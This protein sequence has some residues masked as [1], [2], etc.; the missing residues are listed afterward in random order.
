MLFSKA[1][2][3]A[4]RAALYISSRSENIVPIREISDELEISFHF[5]TKILQQLTRHHILTSLKGPKGGVGLNKPAE[6]ISLKSIVL[7]IDGQDFF[8]GCLLRLDK[9]SDAHPCPIH[10]E[11]K[12]VR[13]QLLN[14][15]ESTTLDQFQSKVKSKKFRMK[16]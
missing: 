6:E 15:L 12:P 14:F 4:I 16:V 9:C 1:C 7:A 11:W 10:D 13:R 2:H 5:L 3:Y 8:E